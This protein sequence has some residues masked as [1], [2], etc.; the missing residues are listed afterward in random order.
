VLTVWE[1]FLTILERVCL[2]TA[3]GRTLLGTLLAVDN[4]TNLVLQNTIERIIRPA[5]D[6]EMS[7]E[8]SHGLYVVRG[9]N[10]VVVGEVDEELDASIQWDKVRGEGIRGVKNL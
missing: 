10:V 5:D 4:L 2:L 3:D 6:D 8:V 7:Q 1:F 9:E